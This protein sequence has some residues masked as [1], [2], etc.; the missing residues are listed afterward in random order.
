MPGAPRSSTLAVASGV[1]SRG[2]KPGA[3]GRQHDRRLAGELLD[4]AG[5]RVA[6]VRHDPADDLEPLG[7][8]QLLRGQSP[9]RSSLVPRG[10]AVRDGQDSRVH[11]GSFV[12]STRCTSSIDHP[13]VDR[14]RHVVD[15][16]GGDRRGDERL[17]LDA[18]LRHRLGRSR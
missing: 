5:D 4:R 12:F 2:A 14:L 6:L 17:H 16:Q 13:L 8:E 10:H 15:G 18:R 1:T 3:A 11:T 7:L 9:L